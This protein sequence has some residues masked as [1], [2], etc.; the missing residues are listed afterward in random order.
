MATT[1]IN[2]ENM[3]EALKARM[4]AEMLAAAE[5]VIKRAVEEAEKEMRQRLGAMFV[6]LIDSSFSVERNASSLHI[7]VTHVPGSI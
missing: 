4:N 5:P 6:S 3:I 2:S 1:L 7:I